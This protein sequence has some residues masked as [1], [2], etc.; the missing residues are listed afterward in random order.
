VIK[1][2]TE[3][4]NKERKRIGGEPVTVEGWYRE[5]VFD[6]ANNSLS[7]AIAVT[8]EESGEEVVNFD[9]ILFGRRGII[10]VKVVSEAS[11]ADQVASVL[12]EIVEA[13]SFAPGE[14][15]QSWVPGDKVADVT[16]TGLITGG[17]AALGYGAAKTGAISKFGG[18]LVGLLGLLKKLV[19]AL[20]L[21]IVA[22]FKAL[23]NVLTGSGGRRE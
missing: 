20:V 19:W 21:A 12:D 3:Q 8:G 9:S 13:T 18:F 11:N 22:G 10:T 4:A 5:P 15:Y 2:A 6:E 17:A 14:D 16:M 23:W 1:E 7:Y